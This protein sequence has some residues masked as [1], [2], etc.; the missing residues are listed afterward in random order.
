ME[1]VKLPP[2]SGGCGAGALRYLIRHPV[3]GDMGEIFGESARVEDVDRTTSSVR[4][5]RAGAS[6]V[7][8]LR[9]LEE[10]V[11]AAMRLEVNG[12]LEARMDCE[13]TLLLLAGC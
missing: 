9:L 3:V 2:V 6:I 5:V 8:S 1:S 10:S 7:D 12:R 4:S 13:A 11:L